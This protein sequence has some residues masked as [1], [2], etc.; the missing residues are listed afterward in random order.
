MTIIMDSK[1]K[2]VL[3]NTPTVTQFTGKLGTIFC[4]WVWKTST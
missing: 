3:D 2:Q 4:F 1:G